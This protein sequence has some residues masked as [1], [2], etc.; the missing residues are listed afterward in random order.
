MSRPSRSLSDCSDHQR[1]Q[2]LQAQTTL[3]KSLECVSIHLRFELDSPRDGYFH[4][5]FR[6]GGGNGGCGPSPGPVNRS[7]D[8][9][10]P[11][12]STARCT[13]SVIAMRTSL[14]L[15][16][17]AST[18]AAAPETTSS[19][20]VAPSAPRTAAGDTGVPK[21]T[22]RRAPGRG[23]YF[24]GAWRPSG[25]SLS[26]PVIHMGTIVGGQGVSIKIRPL[27]YME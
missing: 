13:T 18:S 20:V 17:R 5:S 7:P 11:S 3:T 4:V 26:K 8:T 22:L 21:V 6:N 14:S 10:R 2:S 24:H 12:A 27:K 1:G 23:R 25:I 19:H 16:R 15:H 9:C